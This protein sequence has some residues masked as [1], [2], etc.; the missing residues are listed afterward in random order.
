MGRGTVS[1]GALSNKDKKTQWEAGDHCETSRLCV[2][3][4]GR[5]Y[6]FM[7]CVSPLAQ[8]VLLCQPVCISV[9]LRLYELHYV[10]LVAGI[11]VQYMGT[12][13]GRECY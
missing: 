8:G 3:D 9:T 13:Q 1:K 10:W 5:Q 6:E 11:E 7:V 2:H 12:A 4:L